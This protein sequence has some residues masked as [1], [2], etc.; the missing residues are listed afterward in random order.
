MIL[1][2]NHHEKKVLLAFCAA[3]SKIHLLLPVPQQPKSFYK[4]KRASQGSLVS[5]QSGQIIT[6]HSQLLNNIWPMNNT[7]HLW[8]DERCT[9]PW[10][11]IYTT[12]LPLV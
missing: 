7:V 1:R 11:L 12:V 8:F 6:S 10:W 3:V 5:C 2:Q 9:A 4:Q